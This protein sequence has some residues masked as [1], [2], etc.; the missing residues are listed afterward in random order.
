MEDEDM[1]QEESSQLTQDVPSVTRHPS[2]ISQRTPQHSFSNPPP[3]A[4][5]PQVHYNLLPP[6]ITQQTMT[7]PSLPMGHHLTMPTLPP[8]HLSVHPYN[9]ILNSPAQGPT[10]HELLKRIE[11]LVKRVESVEDKAFY[12]NLMFAAIKEDQDDIA[13]KN[14]LNK[15]T[16]TGVKIKDFDK[17]AEH[18]KPAAMKEAIN[19]IISMVTADSDKDNRVVVFTR[20]RNGHIRNARSA[21]VEARFE[22]YKQAVAFRKDFVAKIKSYTS[23]GQ[24]VPDEYKGISTYP[25]QT[26]STRVRACLLKEMAKVVENRSGPNVTSYC[27]QFNTR[28]MLKIVAKQG[29]HTNYQTLGFVDSILKLKSHQDLHRVALDEA[30]QIAGSTFRGRLEQ[31]FIILKNN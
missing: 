14:N 25:V 5:Q 15:V 4:Q 31:N 22:D 26:L 20:H 18:E 13:N 28:P 1:D 19:K 3:Q 21:V 29:A 8:S 2:T 16:V 17:F 10:N 12:D 27:Q 9:H 23:A 30:Y 6:P 24:T 7:L 11:E